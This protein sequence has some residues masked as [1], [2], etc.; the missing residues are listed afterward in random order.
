MPNA[1]KWSHTH[2][3]TH[4]HTDTHTH[5]HRYTPEVVYGIHCPGFPN[6]NCQT[7]NPAEQICISSVK[8]IH[9]SLL[10]IY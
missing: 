3:Y 7:L 9:I 2:T 1:P 4:T 8:V 6:C 10:D 5:T